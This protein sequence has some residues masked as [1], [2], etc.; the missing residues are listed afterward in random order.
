MPP[1]SNNTY[2]IDQQKDKSLSS[3]LDS[4]EANTL[5]PEEVANEAV[6]IINNA[7]RVRNTNNKGAEKWHELKSLGPP[8]IAICLIRVNGAVR[9]SL[10]NGTDGY[11][12]GLYVR[13]GP[14][15]GLYIIDENYINALCRRYNSS[16]TQRDI[17]EI[18]AALLDTAPLVECC[19]DPNLVP[20]NNGIINYETKTLMPFDS[21]Y[22]FLSK[23]STDYNPNAKNVIISNPD[24][25]EWDVESWIESLVSNLPDKTEMADLLWKIIGAMVR[26]LVPW[27]KAVF[28]ISP[29]GNN[30]KGTLCELMRSLLGK[31]NSVNIPITNFCKDFMLEPLIN[32]NAV[33]TDENDVG[34]YIEAAANFKAAV[35]G[36]EIQLNRK[37]KAPITFRF[38]GVILQCLNDYP[39]YR[40]KSDSPYRRQL[41]VPMTQCF[42]GA[43]RKYIKAD[44]V[45]RK[46][47][48]EYVLF[49][50]LNMDYDQLPE[51]ESCK[52]ALEKS[53]EM[54]DPVL[55][56]MNEVMYQF[57]WDLV[58]YTFIY[59]L[60]K[61]WYVKNVPGRQ[62]LS[63]NKFLDEFKKKS[64]AISNVDHT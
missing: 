23:S 45:H 63:R 24:G 30:G 8:Q 28:L 43:E 56:F 27:N 26:Y 16:L 29:K 15:A 18:K 35:T 6:E 19:H 50:V 62:P 54:N 17:K 20:V 53:K 51:P 48:L 21:K 47:V 42:T 14:K 32:A 49:K 58:P 3:F 25:T 2:A 52:I 4:L 22:V 12:I 5:P 39:N 13:D 1:I 44:Y 38:R 36:D 60:F 34:T 46:E 57:V 31:G 40:D 41:C 37:Y 11:V 64:T 10:T 55:Q 59:D 61:A 7:I 33:I 9:I